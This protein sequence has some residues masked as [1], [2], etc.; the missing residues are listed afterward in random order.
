[1]PEKQINE[2]KIQVEY[3]HN[4]QMRADGFSTPYDPKDRMPFAV[5]F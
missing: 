3:I 4:S 1:L 5:L 2:G